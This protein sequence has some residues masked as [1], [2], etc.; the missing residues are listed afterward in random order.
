MTTTWIKDVVSKIHNKLS[1]SICSKKKESNFIKLKEFG[2]VWRGY[3]GA[4]K[5]KKNP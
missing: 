1:A 3:F 4:N 5:I 2:I